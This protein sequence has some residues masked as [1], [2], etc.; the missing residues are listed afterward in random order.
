MTVFP[1][2]AVLALVFA[3]ALASLGTS[4][5]GATACGGPPPTPYGYVLGKVESVDAAGN[6]RIGYSNPK[7]MRKLGTL[8]MITSPNAQALARAR[9]LLPKVA[10]AHCAD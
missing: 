3:T 8:P 1:R 4:A 10:N 9:V 2:T 6:A 7:A 5:S